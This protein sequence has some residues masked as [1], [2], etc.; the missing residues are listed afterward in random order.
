MQSPF[1]NLNWKDLLTGLIVAI[2]TA[3]LTYLYGSY[4]AGTLD[5]LNLKQMLLI[6]GG[7]GISYLFTKFG[8][9][10]SGEP[11]QSEEKPKLK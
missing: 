7:A 4:Q 11:L 1:L 8:T 10:S 9:N 5:Q 6:G 2:G 3:L